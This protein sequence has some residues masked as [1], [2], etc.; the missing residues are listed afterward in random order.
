MVPE[1]KLGLATCKA[2]ALAP[3]LFLWS[4]PAFQSLT[5]SWDTCSCAQVIL[6]GSAQITMYGSWTLMGLTACKACPGEHT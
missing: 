3:V 1:I 6:P 4:Y 5:F 2:S